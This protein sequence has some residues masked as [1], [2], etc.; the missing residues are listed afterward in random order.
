MD[1]IR[2]ML[3]HFPWPEQMSFVTDGHATEHA[4]VG[5]ATHVLLT[6][7]YFGRTHPP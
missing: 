2:F 1:A 3:T 4:M 6:K 7:T 5:K